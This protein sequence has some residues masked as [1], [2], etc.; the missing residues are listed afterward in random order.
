IYLTGHAGQ[1]FCAF[2]VHGVSV[3]LDGDSNDYVCKGLSGGRVTVVPPVDLLASGFI[4][5]ANIVVGNACLYGAISGTLFIRGQAAERFCVR[6]SGAMAVVE[7]IGDHGCEYMTGGRVVI[8]G[9]TGNNFAAGMSGGLAFIYDDPE[10]T[11][12]P[13]H[14]RCNKDLVDV[15]QL[16][17]ESDV[18]AIWLKEIIKEFVSETDSQVRKF[19][20]ICLSDVL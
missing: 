13:F 12:T 19:N 15:V 9:Q 5:E 10:P 8:L 17:E 18:N 20:L 3:R 4:S 14:V 6:N 1:S 2:L 11:A 16:S 7:G